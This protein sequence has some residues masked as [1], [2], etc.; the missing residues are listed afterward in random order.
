M[1]SWKLILRNLFFHRRI[2]LAVM[3]GVAAATAVLTGALLVGSSMRGSLRDITLDRLGRVDEIMLPGRFFREALASE[4]VAS[5]RFSENYETATSLILF[6]TGITEYRASDAPGISRASGVV[7]VGCREDFF[8]FGSDEIS[9][10]PMPAGNEIVINQQLAD[11]LGIDAAKV[12]SDDGV[13]LTLRI[14]KIQQVAADSPLGEKEDLVESLIGLKVIKV[15]AN[16]SLGRFGLQPTQL[17]PR[18]AYVS[19]ELLQ[20]VLD[21]PEMANAMVVAGKG[22]RPPSETASA[23]LNAILSPK[24]ADYGLILKHARQAF[25]DPETNVETVLFDYYSFSSDQMML[26]EEKRD[27][28][29]QAYGDAVAQPVLTYL[30]NDINVVDEANAGETDEGIPFSMVSAIDFGSPFAPLDSATG[31]PIA[32]LTENEI[33]LN[34]WAAENISAKVGDTIRL[35]Y[36]EPETAHGQEIETTAEFKLK[37]IVKLTQ[38]AVPYDRK[39]VAEYDEPPTLVNDPDLTPFVPGVTDVESIEQW[40]LPFETGHRIRPE[41]NKYWDDYRTTSKAFVSLAVGKKLWSSRFGDTTTFRL[42]AK[43]DSQEELE[44]RFLDQLSESNET[45]GMQFMPIKRNGF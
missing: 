18:N 31:K 17:L 20:R 44:Q 4:L 22:S 37:A 10:T 23:G 21:Q 33:V 30:A 27:M 35:A 13:K 15:L 28:A 39:Q 12:G 16:K 41:D 43:E 34:S 1:T 38:P 24:F 32:A 36:F 19:I 14:P 29:V 5:D 8:D 7:V 42:S 45:L 6:P 3:L 25:T 2:H 40:N 9:Q 11:D 26:D